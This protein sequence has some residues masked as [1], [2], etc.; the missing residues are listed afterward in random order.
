MP[1]EGLEPTRI[2]PPDPKSGASANSATRAMLILSYLGLTSPCCL[3]LCNDLCDSYA[4]RRDRTRETKK[5]AK[6]HAAR[7][8][9]VFD[10]RKSKIRGLVRRGDRYYAQMRI[11]TPDGKTRPVR[12]PL[13]ATTL[14]GA[15]KEAEE[16]RTQNRKGQMHMPGHRPKFEA[17]VTEYQKSAEFLVK[18]QGTRENEVQALKRWVDHLG[19]VRIDWIKPD[20]MTSFRALRMEQGVSARTSIWTSL[21]SITRCRMP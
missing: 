18:K 7:F 14:D 17:L 5:D 21:P 20:R 3:T 4:M 12:V 1:G 15:K 2:A 6:N 19:G 8:V 13:K 16:K 10:S 9:P 11:A